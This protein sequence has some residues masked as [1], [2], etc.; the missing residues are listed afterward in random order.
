[1][2]QTKPNR[3]HHLAFSTGNMKQQ[4]DFFTDVLGM[5]LVAL[6]WMHGVE[7]AMHG[8]LRLDESESVAFVAT[9]QNAEIEPVMGVSHA[10]NPGE[11]SAP[12]TLQHLALNVNTQEELLNM[13]DR[14]RSRGVPVLGPVHHGLCS[15][16][17]FA[18]P[19]NMALE[20]ATSGDAPHPMHGQ[21]WID[22]EVVGLCGISDDELQGYLNPA[23]YEGEKGAVA[24]PT[25]DPTKP[26]QHYPKEVY[27]M[28]L[29][30]PD[31]AIT[32]MIS[33]TTPPQPGAAE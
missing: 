5:E 30:T 24:Q 20:I 21:T 29:S 9:Q 11:S 14:I 16:I 8:F 32:E 2:T 33:E 17:Y 1:M 18:G 3:L 12:G 6:Y 13:R 28:M 31:E 25:Y 4:I 27:D 7:G 10:G 23:T 15:S 19:E 22:P 26:H